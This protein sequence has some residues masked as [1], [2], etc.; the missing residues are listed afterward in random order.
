M[1]SEEKILQALGNIQSDMKSMKA[2]IEMLKHS[3]NDTQKPSMHKMS[4][5]E[6]FHRM[7]ELLSDEEKDDFGKFMDAEEARKAALYG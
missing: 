3:G 4:Q 1:S 2:D 7:S 5:K 6:V